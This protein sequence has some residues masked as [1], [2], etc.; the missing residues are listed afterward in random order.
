MKAR[1]TSK[2]SCLTEPA[3]RRVGVSTIALILFGSGFCALVYQV[4]WLRLLRLIFGASTASS[5]AV[6]AIFMGGLGIGGLILGRRADRAER[7][8]AFY[9]R[10][11]IGITL[12]AAASPLLI[13]LVRAAYV[14]LGGTAALG[15]F[16]GTIVRLA[17]ATLVLGLPTF[18]MGGTLPAMARAATLGDD[19]GRRTVA[20]LYG[21]NTLGA[22]A[23]ALAT[24]FFTLEW[25]GVRMSIFAAAGLNLLLALLAL[26]LGR[27]AGTSRAA[28]ETVARN[29]VP[30]NATRKAPKK[31]ASKASRS[32]PVGFVLTAAALVG[33]AFLLMELVWYRMLAPILGGSSYTFGLI[34]AVALAG[35]GLGGL[36]YAL[37]ARHRRP[38]LRGFAVTCAAEALVLIIP[39]A[40]GDRIA[41]LAMA[42]R[43]LGDAGFLALAATWV[44]ITAI[45]VLPAAII[46]GYQFPLLVAVLGQ[47]RHDLGRQI[48]ATYAWNTAGA[49]V[50]SI[51]G[52]F[53]LLP[54]MSAP[55]VWRGVT[56]ML[57]A[58]AIAALL[59]DRRSDGGW[60]GALVPLAT[61]AL[62]AA[63]LGATGPTAFWRH[64]PIGAGRMPDHFNSRNDLDRL[65]TEHRRAIIWEAE[66]VESSVGLE[67][68]SQYIFL[69]NGK[70]DGSA[71]RDAPNMVMSVMIGAALHAEPKR[72]L[73]IGLGSGQSAGWLAEVPSIEQVDVVELEPAVLEVAALCAPV[74]FDVLEHPK[75][76]LLIGDGRE[77][78]LTSDSRYDL[79]FSQPSN[80][81]RA[82]IA[83][84]FSQEF[85]RAV[86][87]R[88]A[89]GGLLLQ[90]LQGYEVDGNLVGS[91]FATVG[92][93]FPSVESW[94][95]HE[96]DLLLVAGREPMVYDREALADRLA[97]Y[98]FD[99]ALDQAWGVEGLVGLFTGY[100]A[101][102]E[103]GEWLADAHRHRLNTDDHP[104]MEFG[105][106]RTLGR[107]GLFD[108]RTL[109]AVAVSRG[110]TR[111]SGIGD[112]AFWSEVRELRTAREVAWGGHLLAP[113]ADTA[114]D[115][116][117]RV[118]ARMAYREGDLTQ[119]ALAWSE[120]TKPPATPIDR[121]LVAESGA[122]LADPRT[123]ERV[124]A[125]GPHRRRE[126]E[127][128]MARYAFRQG[129]IDN[130]MASLGTLFA[131]VREDPWIY[132]PVLARA[133]VLAEEIA[134][135]DPRRGRAL[136]DMLD[137]P[138]AVRL[139][140]E[141]RWRTRVRIA[142][143]IGDAER[144]AR[145]LAAFEP[146]VPWEGKFLLDRYRCYS[147]A[148]HAL[149]SK[150]Q[151][152][153]ERFL[154]Q[155]PP[156]LER[157]L[158]AADSAPPA[159]TRGG[160]P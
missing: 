37:G 78:L 108:V 56:V 24:T 99:R 74:N 19:R 160:G 35:I 150:A 4:A 153:F 98:P 18:L 155:A 47:G 123:P 34:L 103:I 65:V 32:I 23:G 46:A 92:S 137:T 88:L 22:V 86:D 73:V 25:F 80:P 7:P 95:V 118:G 121:L 54:L 28:G 20:L 117:L 131:R 53:G 79:I 93:V 72:A 9:G 120:Q 129:E 130:A 8:L 90:W 68:Q 113:D 67:G 84:L 96:N 107:P 5:A 13:G 61:A 42:L 116:K 59:F 29:P 89:P 43:P 127:A 154:E 10:L 133:L 132:P 41:I 110:A 126:S 48:G 142:R 144:C 51:A 140:E 139:L 100:L 143:R 21:T 156:R 77:L 159:G 26:H 64:T 136:F 11:E 27:S 158:I 14:A 125:L 138:F 102:P 114:I 106:V 12:A 83:S 45:V 145:A 3:P 49:I 149:E 85:Y 115:E 40:L 135:R 97:G 82:G 152:D 17:L 6:L 36:V 33:F 94:Q 60:R 101:G 30:R 128:V 50:G 104:R 38:T 119:A 146:H 91:A 39:F 66:G 16:L 134:A 147:E 52:G 157:D 58:L 31:V 15:P 44:L 1:S 81:Y 105:F 71:L 57:L 2:V 148:G 141:P 109:E 151:A 63:L 55:T 87:A 111:A 124:Q 69:I 76:N 62:A 122:E 70:A 112:E 75:I